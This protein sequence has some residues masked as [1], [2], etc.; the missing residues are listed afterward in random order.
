MADGRYLAV[1]LQLEVVAHAPVVGCEVAVFQ[2][3]GEIA[4]LVVKL[5]LV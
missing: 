2:A 5:H 3:N 1:I 4:T